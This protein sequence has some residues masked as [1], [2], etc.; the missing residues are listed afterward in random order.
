MYIN[1]WLKQNQFDTKVYMLDIKM[2]KNK[3]L[4]LI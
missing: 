3:A 1:I 2:P 4:D